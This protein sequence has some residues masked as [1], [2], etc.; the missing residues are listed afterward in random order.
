[1]KKHLALGTAAALA[2]V[3][4]LPS[5]PAQADPSPSSASGAA[6]VADELDE[7]GL[8]EYPSFAAVDHGV[9]IDA[10]TALLWGGD[11]AGAAAVRDELEPIIGDY[12]TGEAF[13]DTG[14]TYANPLA[15]TL[16]FVVR[17]GG[18]TEDFGGFDLVPRLEAQVD[19]SG[20]LF[21]TS[22]FGDNGN[23][24]GQAFAAQ[25]LHEADG[26]KADLVLDYLLGQQCAD[27]HFALSFPTTASPNPCAGV[28]GVDVTALVAIALRS[29]ADQAAVRTA[30]TKAAA[31]VGD[32][33]NADGSI[34]GAPPTTD[35]NANT[36]GLGAWLLGTA[37]DLGPANRAAA[38][39]RKLQV[40]SAQAGTELENEVGAIAYDQ[41][42]FDAGETDG[43]GTTTAER[44]QWRRGTV[45]AA[46]GLGWHGSLAPS[47]TL[48]GPT[49]F[50]RAGARATFTI[51][52]L[53]ATDQLPC[54][55]GPSGNQMLTGDTV[56]TTLPA[57]TRTTRYGATTG[58]GLSTVAVTTLAAKRLA[59]SVRA[60][61]RRNTNQLVQVSGLVSG[62][63]VRVLDGTRVVATGKAN[64]AGKFA[65]YYKVAG[66][67][68]H[69]V[70]VTGHFGN[71]TGSTTYR[72]VR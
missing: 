49:G 11:A 37:C 29:Q 4:F 65:R 28:A 67:G 58:P 32:Q 2:V 46:V 3:G 56:T 30:I 66:V 1:M 18:D 33:Q 8:F 70:T 10:G 41:A 64:A 50:Q 38:W 17:T 26:A 71:R 27:G 53:T 59:P 5:A 12:V 57:T 51:G 36:T 25:G 7:Y 45:Q 47:V 9:N 42:A 62:E 52:G 34:P 16:A 63:S 35:P 54:F 60:T 19:E 13:G 14:S 31:W 61:I 40:T 72:V 48:S 68:T 23:M 15:K 24:I 21:D 22:T 55:S 44:D 20:R 43:I 6:W 39:V 69:R